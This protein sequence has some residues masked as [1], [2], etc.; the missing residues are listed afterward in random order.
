MRR[1]IK[2][3]MFDILRNR[4]VIGYCLF[5]MLITFGLLSLE[6][7]SSKSTLSLLNIVLLVVP[8]I[9]IVFATIHFYN[10]YE[11]MELLLSQPVRRSTILYSEYFGVSCSLSVAFAIGMGVPLIFLNQGLVSVYLLLSGIVLTF[12]FV[13]IALLGAV[14]SK[15]K[16][17]GI[18]TSLL[19]W[20]FFTAIY[21][22]LV[23]LIMFSFSDYPIEK[24]LLAFISLNPIDLAR[25]AILLQ[26]DTAVLMGYT[27][28]VFSEF[29]NSWTGL[30]FSSGLLLLWAILPMLLTVRIFKRKDL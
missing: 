27:G 12:V 20:F 18:G 28:A 10:S 1:I 3:V 11:F 25:V 22:G 14:N 4:F 23:L 29:F 21:D 6:E 9:S 30:L 8:L 13:S 15:D 19:L 2:Y 16:A 24:Y 17:R 7:G 26:M 5:I